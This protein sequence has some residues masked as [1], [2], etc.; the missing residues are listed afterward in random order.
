LAKLN[1]QQIGEMLSNSVENTLNNYLAEFLGMSTTSVV[2][3]PISTTSVVTS[4]YAQTGAIVA[5][6]SASDPEV[7]EILK[8][9]DEGEMEE[10]AEDV[11][12]ETNA[13]DEKLPEEIQREVANIAKETIM[14]VKDKNGEKTTYE[15]PFMA[16]MQAMADDDDGLDDPAIAAA[17]STYSDDDDLNLDDLPAPKATKTDKKL[18]IGNDVPRNDDG[19]QGLD[20]LPVDLGLD[21][22]AGDVD[23]GMSGA[24]FFT[25]AIMGNGGDKSRR[26]GVRRKVIQR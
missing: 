20:I 6:A 5:P 1:S 22:V 13:L 19:T 10:L 4:G 25:N 15:D 11:V 8:E 26:N 12:D 9:D 24:S 18:T 16:D 23:R 3:N 17:E 21:H 14:P 2:A 7:D